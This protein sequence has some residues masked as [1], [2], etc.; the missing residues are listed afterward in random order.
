LYA[1]WKFQGERAEERIENAC[2]IVQLATAIPNSSHNSHEFERLE[3]ELKNTFESL[4]CPITADIGEDGDPIR[5]LIEKL[6]TELVAYHQNIREVEKSSKSDRYQLSKQE[7]I[8][9]QE[10]ATVSLDRVGK[11]ICSDV[12]TQQIYPAPCTI[13]VS[14]VATY[15]YHE[16]HRNSNAALCLSDHGMV[17]QLHDHLGKM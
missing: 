14:V 5:Q 12:V 4:F 1:H 13:I 11:H 6:T 17:Q 10:V 9:C 16:I 2:G 3:R 7:I 15:L 8:V